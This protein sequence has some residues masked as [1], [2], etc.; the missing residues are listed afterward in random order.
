MNNQVPISSTPCKQLGTLTHTNIPRYW[1]NRNR[2]G[3]EVCCP[4]SLA[5]QV[6]FK[7]TERPWLIYKLESIWGRQLT[8]DSICSLCTCVSFACTQLCTYTIVANIGWQFESHTHTQSESFVNL[9][10]NHEYANLFHFLYLYLNLLNYII[11]IYSFVEELLRYLHPL[12]I[13]KLLASQSNIKVLTGFALKAH[14]VRPELST[15]TPCLD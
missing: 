15:V 8:V 12:I 5:K 7:F 2:R 6:I 9:S 10:N 11:L 13:L 14:N 3:P 1:W 4:E